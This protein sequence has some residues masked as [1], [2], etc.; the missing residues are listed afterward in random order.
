MPLPDLSAGEDPYRTQLA[1]FLD[2][3]A[4]RTAPLVRPEES[5]QALR[6]ALAARAAAATNRV[7]TLGATEVS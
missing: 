4:G 7:Q 5:W 1:H 2:V 3:I 6:L